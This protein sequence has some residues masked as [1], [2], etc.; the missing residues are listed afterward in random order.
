[1]SKAR[2]QLA[3]VHGILARSRDTLD[4]KIESARVDFTEEALEI[5]ARQGI[6]KADLAR[7]L[8]VSKPYVT[9]LLGGGANLT[10]ESMVRLAEALDCRLSTHLTEAGFSPQ[11]LDV[12][13]NTDTC[14]IPSKPTPRTFDPLPFAHDAVSAAA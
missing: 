13:E 14:R 4:Y 10:L 2:Q 3:R 6:G 7:K 5:M 1:M 9:K 12:S 11:W 8:G